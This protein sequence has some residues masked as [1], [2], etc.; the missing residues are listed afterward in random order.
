MLADADVV[1]TVA[2]LD[3]D[4]AR[5]LRDGAITIGFLPVG[6]EPDLVALLREKHVLGFAME[7]V[8]RISRAQ[9]MDAL[10]SQ[11]LVAGYRCALVAAD[12]CRSS[13]RCS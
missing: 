3:L 6:A 2:P 12:G 9:S 1:T 13:S 10:S 7:A 11:A 8:P 4:Q 5:R